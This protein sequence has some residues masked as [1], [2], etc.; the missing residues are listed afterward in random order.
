MLTDRLIGRQ[1]MHPGIPFQQSRVPAGS[2]RPLTLRLGRR[3]QLDHLDKNRNSHFGLVL[4]AEQGCQAE[5]GFRQQFQ[6][7]TAL[8]VHLTGDPSIKPPEGTTQVAIE[9]QE[10]L[11]GFAGFVVI[12]P[13]LGQV[14]PACGCI[15]LSQHRTYGR[16]VESTLAL[17]QNAVLG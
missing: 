3:H 4:T 12:S 8:G 5:V 2:D 15:A 1:P 6:G 11:G 13:R 10:L 17:S 14:P 7:F 9:G 16:R